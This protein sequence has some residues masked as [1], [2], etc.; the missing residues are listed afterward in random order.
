MSGEKIKSWSIH[1]FA[2]SARR[3]YNRAV[4][5]RIIHTQYMY[6]RTPVS[7]GNT[8]QNLSPFLKER[9]IPN[10]IYNVIFA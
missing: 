1:I 4:S 2:V 6:R 5:T 9:I 10:A 8:F 3:T 7:A